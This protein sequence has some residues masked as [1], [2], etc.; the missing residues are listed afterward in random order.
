MSFIVSQMRKVDNE[1]GTYMT[2]IS[3]LLSA[4]TIS[5]PNNF[6]GTD[7]FTDF[8]LTGASTNF[9]FTPDN[10]YFLRFKIHK[11]PQYFYSGSKTPGQV[12]SYSSADEL[13]L[14]II[15][16]N[17]NQND[18]EEYPPEVI[19]T[20]TVPKGKLQQYHTQNSTYYACDEYSSYSFVFSP[21]K[22]F[23]S[24]GFRVNRTSFDAIYVRSTPRTWLTDTVTDVTEDRYYE[25]S[26][27]QRKI[28]T[29]GDRIVYLGD[30]A[31]ICILNNIIPSEQKKWLKFGYQSRPGSL[32]VVNRQP[33]R[34]GRSGIY[35]INNG[36]LITSFMIASP[37]GSVDNNID[38]FL[39]DYAYEG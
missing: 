34:V 23:D 22:S 19:G 10:V 37:N 13:G 3:N 2:D 25:S 18:E 35:E 29:T 8:A 31:D 27:A 39:L 12:A 32:I 30:D 9:N 1:S 38:A 5:S 33:I 21:T 17:K 4:S 14:Q 15:L 20:C 28:S 16:K 11:I 36:T 26:T 24:L 6:G 7:T